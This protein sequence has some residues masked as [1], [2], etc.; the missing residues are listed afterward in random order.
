M[1]CTGWPGC[2][3]VSFK[4]LQHQIIL[5]HSVCNSGRRQAGGMWDA[6]E[7]TSRCL[8]MHSQ[9]CVQQASRSRALWDDSCDG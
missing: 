4:E 3:L 7:V 2:T 8:G 5:S 6:S 9:L 1:M